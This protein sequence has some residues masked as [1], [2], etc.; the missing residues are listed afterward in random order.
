MSRLFGTDGI[1]GV[2]N[3]D[4]KPTLAYA[5][6][7]ATAHRLVGPGGAHRRRPGHPALGRHVRGG[8]HRRRDEP[9]RRRARGRRRPDAGPR[10]P[11]RERPVRGRDHGLGLAQPGRR[12]RPQGARRARASSSTTRS[13]TSSRP[14][15]WRAEELGGVAQRRAR[16]R[17]G[18]RLGLLDSLPRASA[19]RWPDAIDATGLR[20]VLDARTAPAASS[21]RRSSRRP[22]R[23]SRSI[24]VEP[25]GDQHQRRLRAPRRPRRWPRPS[26]E[27]GAD[28][29]FALDGDADR[30]H[31]GGRQRPRRRRRP[32]ARHPR[33]RPARPRRAC[34]GRPRRVGPLERR[35]PAA[36]EAAG[37]QVVRTPVGDKYILEG[38]AGLGRGA[39]RREE[40]PRD[41]AGA[42]HVA[43][44]ASSPR[45]RCC[46]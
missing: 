45:S 17:R 24:H 31:R 43:A 18:R 29:G 20:I 40:R 33:A 16:P 6:G 21:A 26:R 22:A 30:L 4:L 7:R 34:P 1:R 25:D 11:R 14:L 2:A 13:R 42:H 37:G 12:Q 9:R 5:L 15:I 8:D 36:V 39:R 10:V 46:A 35:A 44:T 19:R 27:R 28:V 41:R 38:D 3:V 23:A 32:G